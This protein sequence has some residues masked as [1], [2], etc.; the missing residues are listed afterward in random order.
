MELEFIGEKNSKTGTVKEYKNEFYNVKIIKSDMLESI[1][2]V[3]Q[4]IANPMLQPKIN[5]DVDSNNSFY[6]LS[7]VVYYENNDIEKINFFM[8]AASETAE[9]IKKIIYS[10][11]QNDFKV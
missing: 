8:N 1:S 10:Q 4:P 2:V 9:E 6:S 5:F 11:K 3:V 7:E